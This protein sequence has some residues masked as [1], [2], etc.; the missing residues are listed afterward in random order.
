MIGALPLATQNFHQLLTLS[1]GATSDLNASAQ[2]GR[3]D[4]GINVN[5]QRQDNNN[6]LLDGISVTDLRNSE[7][8]NTP[9]PSPDAVQEFKVQTSLYDATEGRNGG[10]NINAVLKSGT[11]HWHG[12]AFEFFRNDVLNA[13]EYF[14]EREGQPRPVVKQNLFGGSLGGPLGHDAK[15]RLPV[16]QLPGHAPDERTFSGGD[17][18]HRA[19]R[20]AQRPFRRLALDGWIRQ[21]VYPDRSRRARAAQRQ[22]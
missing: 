2:L 1:A 20:V 5:G 8:F 19:S 13:N 14:Q 6:Y 17:H 11:S 16:R 4:V 10:G 15:A 22:E 21:R 3:G 7:L 18:Q 9:L 12:S